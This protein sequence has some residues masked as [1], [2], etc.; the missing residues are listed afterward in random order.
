MQ[1]ANAITIGTLQV[2]N[3]LW[4][5]PVKTG[6]GTPAGDTTP[7]TL[8]Y[9]ERRARGG[10]G[11]I[12]S[13]PI[14]VDRRG[15][16]HPKQLG[17]ESDERIDSLRNLADVIHKGGAVA[18][19][20]L[21]H[22]GRAA[23]P[24]A[25]GAPAEA[26]SP[27]PCPSTG[28]T[29]E[30]LSLERIAEIVQAFGN[31]AKRVQSAGFDAIE[32]QFGLGYLVS[33]FWSLRTNKRTDAYGGTPE[34]RQRFGKE[35]LQA[36]RKMVGT[37]FPIIA[38]ISASEQVEGGLTLDD[39]KQ[40]AAFLEAEGVS[41]LHVVTGS[42][43]DTPPWYYQHMALPAGK[44]EELCAAI[45]QSTKLPVIVAGRMGDPDKIEETL[46][47][48]AADAV[49]LGRALVADPDLPD[50]M[51]ANRDEEIAY[52]GHCLQGCLLKVKTGVGIGCIINPEVGA[53]GRVQEAPSTKK[54]IVVIGG[55]P[56]GLQAALTASQRG[57]RVTLFEARDHL[58]GQFEL[59]FLVPGKERMH[60]PFSY[61]VNAAERANITL[62]KNTKAD[63]KRII[64]E[65]P[66]E[67]I[68]ATGS[69]PRLISVDGLDRILT[70]EDI[71]TERHDPG[72]RVLIVGGGLVG[73]ESAEFL[74]KAGKTPVIVEMLEEIARDMEPVSRKLAMK[75]LTAAKVEIHTDT[76]LV[77]MRDGMATIESRG[78]RSEI[79]PFDSVVAAVGASPV[80]EL[81][82][83]LREHGISVQV[84]GDASQPRQIYDAVKEGWKAAMTV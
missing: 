6:Y 47:S 49:A 79:G 34:N 61:L 50:K 84:V 76:R 2:K 31:A 53:E 44:N 75:Q 65:R 1:A 26:P 25:A 59:A 28:Q 66:D 63:L 60:R 40:M 57:H 18:I 55:G 37:D 54:Q 23:N 83:V 9:F 5:A 38:R 39:A 20:H 29:P 8:A 3:R 36:I 72:E 10:A 64:N 12:I 45:K 24:K 48:G 77:Y 52:C 56:A 21:N 68:L 58:G 19:A 51:L 27:V 16:E 15:R 80:D 62:H 41:A 33:Q 11:A 69:Q 46:A 71:L 14:A 78:Q 22:A 82:A 35:V 70:G 74:L 42:A 43:C 32:I 13:E 4:M 30:E 81:S 67:V 17:A 73:V 7:Q